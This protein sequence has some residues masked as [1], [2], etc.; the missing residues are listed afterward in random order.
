MNFTG[1]KD[2]RSIHEIIERLVVRNI[3]IVL[4]QVVGV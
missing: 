2:K 1:I 4:N 3:A